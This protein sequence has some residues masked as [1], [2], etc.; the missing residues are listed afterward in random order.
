M[1][2]GRTPGDAGD[3]HPP[4]CAR[5]LPAIN[6]R[7]L[8]ASFSEGRIVFSS[9]SAST[10]RWPGYS[11]SSTRPF[12]WMPFRGWPTGFTSLLPRSAFGCGRVRLGTTSVNERYGVPTRKPP[13]AGPVASRHGRKPGQ[14]ARMAGA[15]F[16]IVSAL[17]EWGVTRLP[18]LVFTAF[19]ALNP[20]VLYYA[21]NGMSEALYLFTLM[22]STRY[23]LRW[24]RD[25]DLRS[26]AYSAVALGLLL[27]D[28][29]RSRFG[30]NVG[31]IAVGVVSYW[32]A[33]G[34]RASRIRTGLSELLVFAAPAFT[35]QWVGPSRSYVIIGAFIDGGTLSMRLS[36]RAKSQ[37]TLHDQILYV[38]HAIG[39]LAPF[40]RSCSWPRLPWP[41][42]GGIPGCW[43]L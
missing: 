28:S 41:S 31:R 33:R 20:M 25:G 14:R 4:A 29:Q 35:A 36:G 9:R 13:L 24:M 3:P 10:S 11:I 19:F 37:E 7:R 18:R 1:R 42:T 2:L 8:T 6:A 22:T 21:G 17:R 38:V 23:L 39:A 5:S 26:L 34:L 40:L 32:R 27:L 43:R 12:R 16:Q 15:A 30:R